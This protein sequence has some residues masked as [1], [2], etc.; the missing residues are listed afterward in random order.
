MVI[1]VLAAVLLVMLAMNGVIFY[2]LRT[3]VRTTEHQ[4]REHFTRQMSVFDSTVEEKQI[5]SRELDEQLAD[6]RKE[7]EDMREIIDVLKSSPFY[8][9]HKSKGEKL[10]PVAHYVDSK[11]FEDYRKAKDLMAVLDKKAIVEEVREQLSYQGDKERYAD[12]CSLMDT[13]NF[14]TVYHLET[15]PSGEQ[16]QVLDETLKEKQHGLF[17]EYVKGLEKPLE[18][19]VLSFLDWLRIQ[20]SEEDPT[21][22]VYTGEKQDNLDHMASDV[23]TCYDENICEGVRLVYQNQVY[24]YSICR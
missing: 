16:L 13:L 10:V 22:Y 24:D 1:L 18:F 4:V 17:L 3:A 21:L 5:R 6:M 8:K 19:S 7:A 14:E 9:P 23:K 11:F 20:R 2:I 15:V 12:I